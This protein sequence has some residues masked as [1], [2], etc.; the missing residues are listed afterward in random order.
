MSNLIPQVTVLDKGLDLQTAKI[1]AP[2]GTVLD[3]LN[4]EQ[5][6]FQG[7][8]RIEGYARYDGSKLSALDEYFVLDMTAGEAMFVGSLLC[9]VDGPQGL[10]GIVVKIDAG[11]VYVAVINDNLLPEAGDTVYGLIDGVATGGSEVNDAYFGVNTAGITPE[12]HY[13]NLLE[14]NAV[15]RSTVEFLPG[16]VVGL[17]WFRDRLYA[18]ADVIAVNLEGFATGIKPGDVTTD[19]HIV[20]DTLVYLGNTIVFLSGVSNPYSVG[21]TVTTNNGSG[22][23]DSEPAALPPLSDVASF[24]ESRSEQQVVEEDTTDFDFGWRFI[25]QGW[26]VKF[27][28]GVSLFGSLPSLNQNISGLG[29]QG[30]TS[31]EGDSGRPLALLQKVDITDAPDQVNGWK[32]S[33]TPLSYNLDPSNLRTEDALYIYADAYFRWTADGTVEAP[34]I[35]QNGMAER[36]PTNNIVVDI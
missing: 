23:V 16:A 5:V 10:I 24:F 25:H 8:K 2:A 35:D 22:V 36:P 18:V 1:I 28:N 30:P 7:Q 13:N 31:T 29:V 17:H 32:S 4:Y 14:F 9:T 33:N 15:L 27:E 26:Q 3:G 12:E 6:D 21:Q 19:G 20:L 11:L 34:G